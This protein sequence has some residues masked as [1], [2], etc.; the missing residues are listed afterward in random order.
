M[1]DSAL[2]TWPL[3]AGVDEL[4]DLL[5]APYPEDV[6]FARGLKGDVIVLGAGGKMGPTLVRRIARAL[7]A[8]GARARLFAVSRFS[9]AQVRQRL[10]D[11]G[12][13]AIRADLLDDEACECRLAD[14]PRCPNVIFMAGMK[15]GATGNEPLTWARNAYLPGRVA[16]HFRDSRIVVLSTGNV[17]P[18]VPASSGGSK[19]TDPP[20]P[21]GEYAQSCLGRE[22]VFAYFAGRYGTPACLLRL[23]YAVEARYGVL[24]DIARRVRSGEPVSVEMG[25]V[26]V[27]WQGDANSAVF[28]SLGL[29]ADRVEIL[30]VTGLEALSV[31]RLAGEFGRRF[32]RPEILEGNE[33]PSALLSD[34]SRC[35]ELLGVPRVPLDWLLDLTAGWLERGGPTYQKPTKF[36]VK[37]GKF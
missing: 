31:R 9:D 25:Y 1:V 16:E 10:L 28:R 37:D 35:R 6:E 7:E 13:P 5:S 11:L 3:P 19:E 14:L 4:E 18:L 30:N 21:V 36:E 12:I 20:A 26:N 23:N 27:I 24:L 29:C 15:F 17:Y 2:R 33:S 22:R 34:A 8:A 32:G